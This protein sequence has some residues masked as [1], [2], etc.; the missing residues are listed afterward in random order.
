MSPC[1]LFSDAERSF[2]LLHRFRALIGY[3]VAAEKMEDSMHCQEG[4]L[5]VED[6]AVLHRLA[7]GGLHRDDD[8]PQHL[9][10]IL[11]SGQG[12]WDRGRVGMVV[13]LGERENVRRLVLPPEISVECVNGGVVGKKEAD[14]SSRSALR[15]ERS[16]CGQKERFR[17]YGDRL[18]IQDGDRHGRQRTAPPLIVSLPEACRRRRRSGPER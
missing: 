18:G 2:L 16:P 1:L 9:R 13:A 3:V 5:I 15:A 17:V 7:T 11:V 14:F 10:N 6:R 12:F 4:E 8:I